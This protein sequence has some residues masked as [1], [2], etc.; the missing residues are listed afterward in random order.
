MTPSAYA[1]YAAGVSL[2]G[3]GA[4]VGFATLTATLPN[5]GDQR[6][7]ISRAACEAFAHARGRG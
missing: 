5:L 6:R 1:P 7:Q 3:N 2:H 4:M